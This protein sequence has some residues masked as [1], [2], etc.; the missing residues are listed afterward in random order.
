MQRL[1][2][3][4][5]LISDA[6]PGSG[7]G[8]ELVDDIVP[9]A[10]DGRP[11]I[12][13]SHLKG[14]MREQLEGLAARHGWKDLADAVCGAPADR[15]QEG[16]LG[17]IA[18]TDAVAASAVAV[19]TLARTAV[20]DLGVV[21]GQT[22]RVTELL[23]CGSAYRGS[24]RIDAEPGSVLDLAARLGLCAVS[25]VG[26]GRTRGSGACRIT[27]EGEPRSPGQLLNALQAAIA[28]QGL[29]QMA[30]RHPAPS[31]ALSPRAC[32]ARLVFI[33]ESPFCCPEHPEAGNLLRSGPGIPASAVIGALLERLDRR[34]SAMA[35]AVFA[36][37]AERRARC[38]PLWPCALPPVEDP[39]VR[40]PV[41][42]R[43]S[44]T[45]R[46]S[47]LP[48]GEPGQ[49]LFRDEAIAP[50]DWREVPAHAPLKGADGFLLHGADGVRLWRAGDLPRV[51]TSHAVHSQ[52]RN[53]FVVES[54]APLVCSGWAWLPEDAAALLAASLRDDPWVAF[55]KARSV[56]GL[57]RLTLQLA[58][59][60]AIT[61]LARATEGRIFI[62]QSPLALPDDASGDDSGAQLAALA[63][64]DGW[65]VARHQCWARIGIRF[66]WNRLGLGA[67]VRPGQH[68]LRARRCIL[69]GSVLVL[70]RP[71]DDP[72]ARLA[73]G[74]GSGAEAGFGALLP[75]PG[76]AMALH[77]PAPSL[78]VLESR[79]DDASRAG[80]ELWQASRDAGLSPSQ[81]A[82][83]LAKAEQG[84][85]RAWLE[86]Q[87]QR[88]SRFWLRWQPLLE[89]TRLA[90]ILQSDRAVAALRVWHD[91]AVAERRQSGGA[92]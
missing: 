86:R 26:G 67:T 87:R 78:A 42:V 30:Q 23:P 3:T 24:L 33:A 57:G 63:E 52:G 49:H 19:R 48:V 44:L 39:P 13:A 35:S 82:A 17:A 12:R 83:L 41:P 61:E 66:G 34:D 36:A 8:G 68:R 69:P 60:R 21:H 22:L 2:Y 25:S 58:D 14:L 15:G 74:L 6:E 37:L 72:W 40:L 38:W 45:H 50:Y 29:P 16:R 75:H 55:G 11:C 85:A 84:Q 89:R 18:L 4:I 5:T 70:S 65:P 88:P 43:V 10:A 54:L 56:R 76:L 47:K 92:R 62:V 91:L 79:I 28:S 64:Q 1:A 46:M 31:R 90:D 7:C 27:I 32:L 20:N 80:Y 71:L 73:A 53:L 51:L 9:R 59:E 81:V 77:Q